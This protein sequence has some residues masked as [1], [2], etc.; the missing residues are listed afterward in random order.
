MGYVTADMATFWGVDVKSRR[1][2]IWAAIFVLSYAL[3]GTRSRLYMPFFA[4]PKHMKVFLYML[5]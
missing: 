4:K 5:L 1:S 3:A 2:F